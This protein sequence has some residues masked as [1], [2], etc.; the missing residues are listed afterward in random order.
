[1]IFHN[2]L[3]V[4]LSLALLLPFLSP[5]LDAEDSPITGLPMVMESPPE[6]EPVQTSDAENPSEG[7]VDAEEAEGTVEGT[8]DGGEVT[9]DPESPS[10]APDDEKEDDI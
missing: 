8:K 7:V 2:L 10:L 9:T 3:F 1:M 6:T 5:A 4:L